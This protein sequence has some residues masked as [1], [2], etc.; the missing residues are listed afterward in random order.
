MLSAKCAKYHSMF[1]IE[2]LHISFPVSLPLPPLSSDQ[3]VSYCYWPTQPGAKQMYGKNTVTLVSEEYPFGAKEIVVR[4]F[5]ISGDKVLPTIHTV[6][7][8][9]Q[10]TQYISLLLWYVEFTFHLLCNSFLLLCC[11]LV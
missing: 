4:K 8:T 3:E 11:V 7:I 9:T 6:H 10:Y 5:E 1:Y 2:C